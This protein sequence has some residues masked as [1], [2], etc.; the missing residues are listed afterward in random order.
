MAAQWWAGQQ[1]PFFAVKRRT[2]CWAGRM[3]LLGY[4]TPHKYHLCEVR[5]GDL[6]LRV[7]IDK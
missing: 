7:S 6:R 2:R 3:S 5:E 1:G 4:R